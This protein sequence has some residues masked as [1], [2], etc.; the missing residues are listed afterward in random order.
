MVKI[1]SVEKLYDYVMTESKGYKTENYL[2]LL[3]DDFAYRNFDETSAY[4]KFWDKLIKKNKKLDIRF[5][6]PSEY[7]QQ[8]F[9]E[10]SEFGF[11][12]GD[13]LPLIIAPS[14]SVKFGDY[15]R[16]W[17]GFY[18]TKPFLKKRI[19]DVQKEVRIAEIFS[20]LVMEKEFFAYNL[21]ISSHH[22]AITGTCKYPVYLD[23]LKD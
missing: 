5:A 15:R 20:S 22:D 18:T 6:T 17:T 3:G 12:Q 21:C 4:L 19:A 2:L 9:K 14:K 11:Y 8:V 1:N 7:F 23:Y 16:T 10:K 13:F